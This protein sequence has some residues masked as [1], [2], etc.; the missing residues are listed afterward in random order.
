[1]KLKSI[2]GLVCYVKNLQKTIAFYDSLGFRFGKQDEAHATAY[3]NWFWI[4]FVAQSSV[5]SSAFEKEA[6]AASKGT[7]QFLQIN[8]EDVDDFY[9]EVVALGLQPSSEPR[10]WPWGRREFVLRDPDGYKLVFFQKK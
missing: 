5:V 9:A 10:N 7:G 3:V 2:S 4:D 8:V 1:M 6:Q